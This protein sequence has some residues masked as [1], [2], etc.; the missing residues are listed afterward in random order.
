MRGTKKLPLQPVNPFFQVIRNECDD[1]LLA[2]AP[3][4]GQLW[5]TCAQVLGV[6]LLAMSVHSLPG[7]PFPVMQRWILPHKRDGDLQEHSK[8]ASACS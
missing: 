8:K 7:S 5:F 1:A 2:A 6:Y 4:P 3:S